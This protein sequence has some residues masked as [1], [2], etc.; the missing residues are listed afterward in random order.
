MGLH[1]IKNGTKHD[2]CVKR[3]SLFPASATTYDNSQSGL[4]ATRVQGAID[5]VNAKANRALGELLGEVTA[6]GVKTNSQLMDELFA[7]LDLTKLTRNSVLVD[8]YG[9]VSSLNHG[10]SALLYACTRVGSSNVIMEGR[11][12]T[13]S[14]STY[15]VAIIGTG[16]TTFS[17][18]SSIVPA[19]GLTLKIY[20]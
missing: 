12:V 8:P 3:P 4:S 18:N 6:D 10:G 16:G 19:N 1:F 2:V 20:S 11:L 7:Q 9:F 17:N 14:G 5:E 13:A 15:D